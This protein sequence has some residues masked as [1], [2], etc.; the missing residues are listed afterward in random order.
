MRFKVGD[1][2][3]C[4]H[5]DMGHTLQNGRVYTVTHYSAAGGFIEVEGLE[6]Q[7][8]DERFELVKEGA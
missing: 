3:V 7:W 2:V 8:F 1:R 4:T 6:G 5:A